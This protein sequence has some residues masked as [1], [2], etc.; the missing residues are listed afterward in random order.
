MVKVVPYYL[1]L[2]EQFTQDIPSDFNPKHFLDLGCGNLNI[3][4]KLL[5]LY[6]QAH[7]TLLDA[8][9][10]MLEHCQSQFWVA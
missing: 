2:L 1:K 4:Y 3:T 6:P 9:E 10:N 7:Y 5:E 8:S